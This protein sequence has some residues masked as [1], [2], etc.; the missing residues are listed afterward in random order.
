MQVGGD[1]E[2]YAVQTLAFLA[3]GSAVAGRAVSVKDLVCAIIR[4]RLATVCALPLSWKF[5]NRSRDIPDK[6][7]HVMKSSVKILKANL[8]DEF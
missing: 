1:A 6:P 3:A 7:L 4:S 5:L 8:L 2:S